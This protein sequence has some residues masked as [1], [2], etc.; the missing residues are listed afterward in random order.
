M[1]ALAALALLSAC[2]GLH[3][4]VQ[5]LVHGWKT[6]EP[7]DERCFADPAEFYS[8][9]LIAAL[10]TWRGRLVSEIELSW[11]RP[12]YA[13]PL[14]D[15][16]YRYVWLASKTVPGEVAYQHDQWRATRDWDLVR[17]PDQTF[18]C[19]T[20]MRVGPDGVLTPLWV[21]RLGVCAEH[22]EPRP[23]ASPLPGAPVAPGGRAAPGRATALPEV[24]ESPIPLDPPAQIREREGI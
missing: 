4:R 3:D 15:G 10:E 22:F 9:P 2:G 6:C 8:T 14:G 18:E 19:R 7:V 11:G 24:E 17:N 13:E 21:D 1:S 20:Y 12:D 5:D 23:P 16:S